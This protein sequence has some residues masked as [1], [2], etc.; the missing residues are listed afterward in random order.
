M[1]LAH[2]TSIEHPSGVGMQPLWGEKLNGL[3]QYLARWQDEQHHYRK[4]VETSAS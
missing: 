3:R 1:K 4:I 2:E